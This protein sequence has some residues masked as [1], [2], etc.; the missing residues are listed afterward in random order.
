MKRVVSLWLPLFATDRLTRPGKALAEWRHLPLATVARGAGGMRVAAANAAARAAGVQ[1]GLPATDAQAVAP[2]L[3]TVPAEPE[4]EAA[5]LSALAAWCGRWSPLTAPEDGCEGV[6]VDATGCTHLFGGER[7]MLDDMVARLG[8]LGFTVRAGMA[9]TPGAAWAMARFG[10]APAAILPEGAARQWLTSFPVAALRLPPA[11]AEGLRRLGL[12]RVG[13]IAGLPRAPLTRRF[14]PVVALRLDQLFG[15][16]PEPLSP[17][18]HEEPLAARLAFA[19]PIGRTEDVRA[20]ILRLLEDVCALLVARGLGARRLRLVLYRV[21]GTL[22]SQEVG[23]AEALRA[24]AHLLRLFAEGLDGLDAGFGIEVM[25][26]TVT[27]A[28]P[29]AAGQ[30]DLEARPRG[31]GLAMLVDRLARRLGPAAV[32]RL[33]ARPTHIPERL[34][35]RAPPLAPAGGGGGW[36]ALP[37]RPVRLLPR[38]QPVAVEERDGRPLALARSLLRAAHGPE[39]IAAE[40]WHGAAPTPHQAHRDYWRVEDQW[41]R[42]LWLF[43]EGEEG[44][45]F[46][47]GGFG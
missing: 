23:T 36:P 45:W 40:W 44:R 14:G 47:Q 39:R 11:V 12:R 46:L 5:A 33:A 35:S 32:H 17:L 37:P 38:P 10:E 25:A 7:A 6:W 24:P 4:A 13:D 34:V 19:E 1:P 28:D 16:L 41:G 20:A 15:R 27:A 26:M 22:L 21:D 2:G 31:T 42:R 8:G 18:A 43:R 9:E 29:F 30:G 3:K